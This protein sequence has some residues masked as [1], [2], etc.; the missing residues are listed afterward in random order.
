[1]SAFAVVEALDVLEHILLG[2]V[3]CQVPGTVHALSFQQTEEALNDRI[4]VAVAASTHA[5][6]DAVLVELIAEVIA[7]VLGAAVRVM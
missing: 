6:L 3:A 4:V 2:F 5:A 1:M 7:G